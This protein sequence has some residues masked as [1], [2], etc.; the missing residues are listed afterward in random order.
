MF[1]VWSFGWVLTVIA[2]D[3]A[4]KLSTII[5]NLNAMVAGTI[6]HVEV[7]VLIGRSIAKVQEFP[8]SFS[9]RSNSSEFL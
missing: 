2:S 9:V 3:I 1:T 5:Q 6:S 8:R 4:Q 7:V